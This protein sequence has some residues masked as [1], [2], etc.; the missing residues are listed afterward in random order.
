MLELPLLLWLFYHAFAKNSR[1]IIVPQLHLPCFIVDFSLIVPDLSNL[2]VVIAAHFVPIS[3]PLLVLKLL[4]LEL[5]A[6]AMG[7]VATAD[8]ARF[9]NF[10]FFCDR[11]DLFRCT[12]LVTDRRL[13]ILQVVQNEHVLLIFFHSF[14][15]ID[16]CFDSL[17]LVHPC[18]LCSKAFIDLGFSTGSG[19]SLLML[20]SKLSGRLLLKSQ[21]L[22]LLLLSQLS[23]LLFS[24]FN[25]F[26]S[27]HFSFFVSSI[28]NLLLHFNLFLPS[29]LNFSLSSHFHLLKHFYLF[30]P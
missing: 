3:D 26:L 7:R 16:D 29:Q 20:H 28:F 17:Y 24:H 23:F 21:L 13:R 30:L 15:T 27:S 19:I 25:L 1:D 18:L 10:F 8:P 12:A 5:L 14:Y 2:I 6:V 9:D 11:F 4:A 22:S